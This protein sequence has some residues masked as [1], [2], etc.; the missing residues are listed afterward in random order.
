MLDV[1]IFPIFMIAMTPVFLSTLGVEQYGIWMLV[2]SLI[3]SLTVADFGGSNG[4][5]RFISLYRGKQDVNGVHRVFR[6]TCTLYLVL[7][8]GIALAGSLAVPV[9]VES[10]VFDVPQSNWHVFESALEI[11]VLVFSFK[12]FEQVLLAYFKGYERYDLSSKLSMTSKVLTLL[13]QFVVVSSG[14]GLAEVFVGMLVVQVVMVFLILN[15]IRMFDNT[16]GGYLAVDMATLK[17][18]FGFSLWVWAGSVVGLISSQMDKWVVGSL[19]G[20]K[21]LA[22]YSIASLVYNQLRAVMAAGVGWVF[23]RV[24]KDGLGVPSA[25]VMYSRLQIMMAI[26]GVLVCA[27]LLSLDSLFLLWLGPE[28]HESSKDYIRFFLMLLPLSAATVIPY[29]FI[30]GGGYVQYN[31]I[32]KVILAFVNVLFMYLLYPHFGV[33]GLIAAYAVGFIIVS[34]AQRSVFERIVFGETNILSGLLILVPG[35][36]FIF[37]MTAQKESYV[38]GVSMIVVSMLAFAV[39]AGNLYGRES[40]IRRQNDC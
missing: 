36:L 14:G 39:L 30:N 13:S 26:S 32:Y 24:S 25:R 35:L 4:V 8:V 17:E 37:G 11:G 10:G 7:G 15:S 6:A 33:F 20:M 5:I 38:L 21:V 29:F 3:A 9:V 31:V 18:I 16:I 34:S 19:G 23:P 27:L 28:V 40:K 2:N 22:Y 12:L 1:A